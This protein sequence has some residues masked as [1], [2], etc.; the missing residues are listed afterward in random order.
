[1]LS[2]ARRCHCPRIAN[3]GS[4]KLSRCRP[5]QCIPQAVLWQCLPSPD[6][7]Y[8][9]SDA[10]RGQHRLT[11]IARRQPQSTPYWPPPPHRRSPRRRPGVACT[12]PDALPLVKV[13]VYYLLSI[14]FI[15]TFYY[16]Q[17]LL[18]LEYITYFILGMC[19][20]DFSSSVRFR[21]GFDKNRGFGSVSVSV[22]F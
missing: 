17:T 3:K 9:L 14:K 11:A 5:E 16:F 4:P 2:P 12:L 10:L 19:R 18:L 15:I 8:N 7:T 22:R 13:C 1:M 21:F 6:L 20:M